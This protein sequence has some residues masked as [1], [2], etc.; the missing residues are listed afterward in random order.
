MIITPVVVVAPV[1]VF[2]APKVATGPAVR[3]AAR[4]AAAPH[5]ALVVLLIKSPSVCMLG[6]VWFVRRRNL[7]RKV[8]IIRDGT[9]RPLWF[10]C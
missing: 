4:A 8:I 5:A 7:P 9:S 1:V 3:S 6:H 10:G 2:A